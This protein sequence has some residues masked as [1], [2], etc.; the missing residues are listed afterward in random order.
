MSGIIDVVTQEC[1]QLIPRKANKD[2]HSFY[3]QT[4]EKLSGAEGKA[5][6]SRDLGGAAP[7]EA[8]HGRRPP[9]LTEGPAE[10]SGRLGLWSSAKGV[11]KQDLGSLEQFFHEK[12]DFGS[13]GNRVHGLA[14]ETY[15]KPEG[16]PLNSSQLS[17]LFISKDSLIREERLPASSFFNF[18]PSFDN[19]Y[20]LN[21]VFLFFLVESLN[22]SF[23]K[24]GDD[25]QK[26]KNL[27]GLGQKSFPKNL[28]KR[29]VASV[30]RVT[31][32]FI[33]NWFLQKTFLLNPLKL[34]FLFGVFVD[35][36]KVGS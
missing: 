25:P 35:A 6:S 27:R 16:L 31:Q 15:G 30:I 34:G 10:T 26:Q 36:F 4:A 11:V 18:S 24:S 2:N 21:L 5:L 28:E 22:L 9:R 12:T 20:F 3:E 14:D 33:E 17:T 23:L 1:T 7:D 13:K 29:K 19:L 8:P 32:F